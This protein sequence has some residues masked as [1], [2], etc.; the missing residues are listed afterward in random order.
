M[1]QAI[2]EGYEGLIHVLAVDDAEKAIEFY[3]EAFGASE[4]MRMPSPDGRVA[5]AE[6]EIAGSLVMLSDP[7]EQASTTPPKQLGGISGAAM[8]YVDDVDAAVEKAVNAGATVKVPV[9]DQFWGDRYG[10]VTDPFGQEWQLAT[11]TEDVSEEEMAERGKEAM[12]GL[13]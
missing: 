6:L 4:R 2:P 1:A 3:K 11:H 12:A 9:E 7:F 8:F 5:H 13:E 10:K